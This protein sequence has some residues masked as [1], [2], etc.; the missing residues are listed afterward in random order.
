MFITLLRKYRKHLSS[1]LGAFPHKPIAKAIFIILCLS[2]FPVQAQNEAEESSIV[3]DSTRNFHLGF[4]PFHYSWIESKLSK[5]YKMISSHSDLILHHF[6]EGIPWPEAYL[7]KPYNNKVESKLMFRKFQ[8][9]KE[10]KVFVATTPIDF[11]RQKLAGYWAEKENMKMPKEWRSLSFDDPK[12]IRA[13]INYCKRLIDE[14]NP[15]YF[16]YGI[17]V[18][19]LAVNSPNE[20]QR[21]ITLAEQVYPELKKAYPDLPIMLSFYQFPP[22]DIELVKEQVSPL[23]PYTDIYA[24]STYPYMGLN[25]VSYDTASL[26][27]DWYSQVNEIAPGKPFAIA[28]TGYIAQDFKTTFHTIKSN[29]REQKAYVERLL[30]DA[31]MLNAEFVVWFVV[32]DYDELWGVLKFFVNFSELVRAWKDTGLFDGNLNARPALETWD[33]WLDKPLE[34]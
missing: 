17:E 16:A 2:A 15:D 11:N 23:L 7:D 1:L 20:Y 27:V 12:V 18:N 25:G 10:Q 32:A 29:K 13:Y 8:L 24:I 30:S 5:T 34:K 31:Q 4:S 21:F 22:K 26:P 14:F 19:L 3:D 28:E 6:D 9:L 33:E